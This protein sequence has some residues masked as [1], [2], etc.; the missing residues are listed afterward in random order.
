MVKIREDKKREIAKHISKESKNY[1]WFNITEKYI[2]NNFSDREFSK[3][4]ISDIIN[5]LKE[6]DTIKRARIT[7][8]IIY[9]RTFE[10]QLI[11]KVAKFLTPKTFSVFLLGVFIFAVLINNEIIFSLFKTNISG[12]SNSPD[13]ILGDF[14]VSVVMVWFLGFGTIK[15][16]NKI[17]EIT[18]S[19]KFLIS[20]RWKSSY[21]IFTCTYEVDHGFIREEI[22]SFL[23]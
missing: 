5:E 22:N 6:E 16:W 7:L 17:L 8:D 14:L 23:F 1:N 21:F 15:L 20:L 11:D 3:E 19:K 2:E 4:K 10:K 12:I 9:P 13:L 18:H